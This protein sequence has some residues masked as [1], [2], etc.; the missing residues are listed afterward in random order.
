MSDGEMYYRGYGHEK[1][2]ERLFQINKDLALMNAEVEPFTIREMIRKILPKNLKPKARLRYLDKGGKDK[3]SADEAIDL[4]LDIEKYLELEMEYENDRK[5]REKNDSNRNYNDSQS[6]QSDDESDQSDEESEY[7]DEQTLKNPCRKHNGAH[8][9]DDCPENWKNQSTAKEEEDTDEEPNEIYSIEYYASSSESISNYFITSDEVISADSIRNK[10]KSEAQEPCKDLNSE[11]LKSIQEDINTLE[12][13]IESDGELTPEQQSEAQEVQAET[14]TESPISTSTTEENDVAFAAMPHLIESK[15]L[16]TYEEVPSSNVEAPAVHDTIPAIE[17]REGQNLIELDGKVPVFESEIES[18]ELCDSKRQEQIM[19]QSTVTSAD[20]SSSL[21]E[22]KVQEHI[23]EF[24]LKGASQ[25]HMPRSRG[26]SKSTIIAMATLLLIM[27]LSIINGLVV[28][29]SQIIGLGESAGTTQVTSTSVISLRNNH[30]RSNSE[31]MKSI[32]SIGSYGSFEN[33]S[34]TTYF[35]PIITEDTNFMNI[36]TKNPYEAYISTSDTYW[37][38]GEVPEVQPLRDK[39]THHIE[40]TQTDNSLEYAPE[41]HINY[42]HNVNQRQANCSHI[43]GSQIMG[44]EPHISEYCNQ[45]SD[46][47][48]ATLSIASSDMGENILSGF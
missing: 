4:C 24:T 6:D 35:S 13:Y 41:F 33:N 11:A 31:L 38:C 37:K 44:E 23:T 40:L 43:Y 28:D 12:E 32:E 27:S 47:K 48:D 46:V 15:Q 8:E 36:T 10:C 26:S 2:A 20:P 29:R 39:D 42:H 21:I 1:A 30:V 16:Q 17:A 14:R 45:I 3:S 34:L 19:H 18:L 7:E 25:P 9:W 5:Q 22:D